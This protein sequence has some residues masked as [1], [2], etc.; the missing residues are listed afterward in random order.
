ML[1]QGDRRVRER[2]SSLAVGVSIAAALVLLLAIMAPEGKVGADTDGSSADGVRIEGLQIEEQKTAAGEVAVSFDLRWETNRFP[3]VRSC[4][5]QLLD[6]NGQVVGHY[7]DTVLS[8][9]PV[10]HGEV[11]VETTRPAESASATCGERLDVGDP[12]RYDIRVTGVKRLTEN[13]VEII[14]D[15]VWA[16]P[17]RPGVMDCTY[18]FLDDDQ[19][20]IYAAPDVNLYVADGVVADHSYS[21]VAE[22]FRTSEPTA[23][24]V[25]C[26]PYGQEPEGASS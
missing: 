20:L 14:F 18:S 1:H 22:Q 16:G 17:G 8:L 7:E 24:A 26:E 21:V 10:V 19:R 25:E 12:Y 13:E 6:E 9:Q 23:G 15:A 5:I 2:L 3:G 4:E 11:D